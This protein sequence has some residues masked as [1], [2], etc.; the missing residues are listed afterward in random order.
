MLKI[1]QSP[2][3][4]VTDVHFHHQQHLLFDVY[5][6]FADGRSAHWAKNS[7][8]L[9]CMLDL[10]WAKRQNYYEIAAG[11]SLECNVYISHARAIKQGPYAVQ[12]V[13]RTS[14]KQSFKIVL[15]KNERN[16]CSETTYF[17]LFLAAWRAKTLESHVT[18]STTEHPHVTGVVL[19]ILLR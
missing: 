13:P 17:D 8:A 14:T 15:W 19:N 10:Q 18:Q 5:Q 16:R 7:I 2:C 6:W 12:N 1:T 11:S 9:T 3:N 4:W